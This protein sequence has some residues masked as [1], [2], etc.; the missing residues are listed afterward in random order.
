M[1]LGI[2]G[3]PQAGKKTLFA[4]LTGQIVTEQATAH[5]PVPGTA[6]IVD[7]RFAELVDRYHPKKETRARIDLVLL[8]TLE[9]ESIARGEVFKDI[10]DVDAICHVVRGFSDDAVYHASGSVD[11]VRD[12]ESINGE[13]IMHDQLFV[14]KR[15]ERIDTALKKLKDEKQATEREL[16]LRMAEMLEAEQP[17]RLMALSAEEDL[18]VRSYPL[19]TRKQMI[20]ALNVGEDQLADTEM[21]A[22]IRASCETAHIE[23]MMVSAKVEAE[24]AMLE[25]EAEKREFLD[26]LGITEPALE[27]LTSLCLK[28]LGRISFF[29]VGPD[30]VHH[31]LVRAG[32]TAPEAAGA[33]HSDLQRGFIRAEVMKYDELINYPGEAELKKAGKF[34]VQGKDYVVA[35]GDII[36]IR[37]S[38]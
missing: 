15:I 8:P 32:A 7:H 28:A 24:I 2:I 38:V 1:K 34:Y 31:W 10:S 13:L 22:Q 9:Q 11:P 5:K 21:M 23:S 4:A 16:M 17:L 27:M 18:V 36:N 33:I 20:V 29:T 30:E 35:D 19:I 14:E 26:D 25:S 12:I 37:F 3:L 6:L